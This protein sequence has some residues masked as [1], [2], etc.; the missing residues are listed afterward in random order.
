MSD[1][2]EVRDLRD[3]DWLWTDKK[4][5]FSKHVNATD[6]KVYSG[7]ASYANNHSQKSWPSINELSKK[8]N[9]GRS[10]VIRSLQRQEQIGLIKI[11]RRDGQSSIYYLLKFTKLNKPSKVEA[12][13]SERSEH[14]K[15]VEFFYNTAKS[16]RGIKPVIT[17]ADAKN[18]KRVLEMNVISIDKMEQLAL[19]F[20]ADGRFR[21]FSP[22]I[23]TFLSSGIIN[24]LMNTMAND[25]DFWKNLDEY[26]RQ[27]M[28]KPAVEDRA[29]MMMRIKELKDK[30]FN[31][32]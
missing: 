18:L 30:L 27:Y 9:V 15:F 6:Y 2:I 11:D 5:L 1:K 21:K 10:T 31:N 12:E 32:F 22:T 16:A 7:L 29:E 13:K 25:Q 23:S 17:G 28:Q 26:T 3:Q 24:G 4:I 19:F 20:L 14:S 8:L